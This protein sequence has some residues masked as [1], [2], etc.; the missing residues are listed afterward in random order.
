MIKDFFTTN[1]WLKLASLVLATT[2]WFFVILSG[3]SEI[4]ID[5]P[6]TFTNIPEDIEIV[7][8]PK[9]VNVTIE[10]QETLLKDLKRAKT[11]AVVDLRNARVGK[12]FYT[13][14]KDNIKIPKTLVITSI[15]PETISVKMEKRLR[16]SVRVKPYIV[17]MPEKG[18]AITDIQVHP[19]TV[20][21]EGPRSAIRKIL[22]VKTE[23]ID[24][25][26]INNDLTYKASL[27]LDNDYIKKNIN[28]VEVNISVKK[29]Q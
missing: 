13:L 3:R 8:Y 18:F 6:V 1:I 11:S 17:G 29:I 19:D 28:K 4:T 16:K 25:N 2:L 21:I 5:I 12:S 20:I 23:P 15:D 9:T 26:G 24:I 7:D 10:G 22:N 14:S 27:N